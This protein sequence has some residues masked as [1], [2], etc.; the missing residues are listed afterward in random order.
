MDHSHQET[1]SYEWG[2][3][4]WEHRIHGLKLELERSQTMY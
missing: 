1:T 2:G 4:K 3:V